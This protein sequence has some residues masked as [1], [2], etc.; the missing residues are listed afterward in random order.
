MAS[1]QIN[2]SQ[3]ALNYATA[4]MNIGINNFINNN[5]IIGKYYSSFSNFHYVGNNLITGYS[6]GSSATYNISSISNPNALTGTAVVSNYSFLSP[7]AAAINAIGSINY[8]WYASGNYL[9]FASTS[10][11][12]TTISTQTLY[13]TNSP[14][15]PATFGDEYDRVQGD[16]FINALGALSGSLTQIYSQADKVI[17]NLTING[18]F[19]ITGNVT[20]VSTNISGTL[21]GYNVNYYDGSFINYDSQGTN[22]Y[23]TNNQTI[24]I[25]KILS[26]PS[27]FVGNDTISVVLPLVL[28]VSVNIA[29]GAGNHAVSLGGGGNNLNFVGSTGNDNITILDNTHGHRIAGGIGTETVIYSGRNAIQFTI[30]LSS[31]GISVSDNSYGGTD[32]LTAVGKIQFSDTS[33]DTSSLIKTASLTKTDLVSIVELY[34]ASFNRAPDSVGLDYWGGQLSNGMSLQDIAKSFFVQKETIAAY[35]TTMSTNDFVSAVYNNVLSRG[36]DTGGLNYWVGQLNN[37][38]VSKDAFLL[39]I[40]NGAMAASG[41]AVDRQTLANKEAV[42]EH[43]AI[44][45]G[46]N[47]STTWAQD[48]MSGVT[49]AASTVTAANAKADNYAVVAANPLTSDLVVKLVGVAV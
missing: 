39:A 18:N 17:K 10:S 19:S 1:I 46:L 41:S 30:V 9:S 4:S 8:T 14:Y 44:Y 28:P 13:P 49:S 21:T 40:I 2:L 47:D 34:V 11:E 29:T 25:S 43:Y 32:I 26:N 27:N 35:P 12:L 38:S 48:V 20:A 33:I 3:S 24:D 31:N 37:G 36:P 5:N 16:F 7:N 42:G 6:D 15:Y 22:P 45:Q 23:L